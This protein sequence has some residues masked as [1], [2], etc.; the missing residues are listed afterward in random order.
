MKKVWKTTR[1][2]KYDLNQILF[3]YTVEVINR[4]K[5]LDL[6]DRVPEGLWMEVSNVVQEAVTKTIS[7]KKK[8]K[9]AKWLSEEDLQIAEERREVK[10]KGEQEG[11]TQLNAEVQ[12]IERRDKKAFLSEQCKEVEGNNR[13]GKTRYLFKKI[14]GIKGIFHVRMGIRKDRNGKDLTEAEE[15][16]KR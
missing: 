1:P 4:L 15:I 7:K 10:D 11:Y 2:F 14:R 5:G 12:G 16:N 13:M 6:V 8:C 3:G 9:K